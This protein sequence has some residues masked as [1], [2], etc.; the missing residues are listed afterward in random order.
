MLLFKI[1]ISPSNRDYVKNNL[2]KLNI[3]IYL[4]DHKYSEIYFN[5]AMKPFL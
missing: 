1:N 4:K 5:K 3:Y 2:I